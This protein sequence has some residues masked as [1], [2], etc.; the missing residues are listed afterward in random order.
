M[1]N[2]G[3]EKILLILQAITRDLVNLE[4]RIEEIEHVIVGGCDTLDIIPPEEEWPDSFIKGSDT[5]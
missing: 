2:K 3:N 4:K 1:N 5:Q